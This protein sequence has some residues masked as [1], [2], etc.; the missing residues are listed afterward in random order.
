MEAV[1]K[2][3]GDIGESDPMMEMFGMSDT[4]ISAKDVS[5]FLDDNKEATEIVVKIN[6]CGGDVQE[7][8]A[9]NDLL[10]TSGKKITTVG[11]GKVYSI[12]TIIFLAGDTRK[13]LKNADGL[14]HN[15]YI[16]PYSL[17][18]KY[19]SDDL[20]KIA[21]GL[22]QEEAKILDYYVERTGTDEDKISEYMKEDT[23]LS[24]E[25]MMSLGFATEIV[26]PVMAYAYIKP[27]K[28]KFTMTEKDVKTFGEKI[29]LLGAKV[30]KILG[31]SRVEP[32]DLTLKDKEG[33]EFKLEKEEG[34][35]TVG[36][37][38]A[39]DGTYVMEDGKTIII[40]E[41]AISD[42]KNAEPDDELAKAND[43][44]AQMETQISDLKAEKEVLETASVAHVAKETE[45]NTILSEVKA[46]KNDW[47]PEGRSK[48]SSAEKVGEV[49]LAQVKE[50]IEKKNK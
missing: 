9:I 20:T 13:M 49:D 41:G 17:A 38:A 5:E 7:G 23:K 37:K 12:A 32:N 34:S 44:I 25:D 43:K 4:S 35:P 2:I 45:L 6:S 40:A 22:Q 26:E 21:E 8:W 1:L 27:S 28:N 47:K 48:T 19:E 31:L 46:L 14:I 18:D 50:I 36:D 42:I 10:T 16:P 30:E 11:E 29:D 33:N 15:P 24:A 3:Y 39:P